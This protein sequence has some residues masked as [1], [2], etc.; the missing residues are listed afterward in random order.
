[1]IVLRKDK[2]K[3]WVVETEQLKDNLKAPS[4]ISIYSY[5]SKDKIT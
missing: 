2:N 4:I 5:I 1:M 3:V